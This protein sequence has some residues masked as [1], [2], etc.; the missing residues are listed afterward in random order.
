MSTHLCHGQSLLQYTTKLQ[1][2]V[3]AVWRT[4]STAVLY[5]GRTGTL[6]NFVT[7][8]KNAVHVN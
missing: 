6:D 1:N 3:P 5:S 4:S 7:V 2:Q 8:V